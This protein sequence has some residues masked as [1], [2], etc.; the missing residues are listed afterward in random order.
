[1]QKYFPLVILVLIAL[2]TAIMFFLGTKGRAK[3]ANYLF[4][5]SN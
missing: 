2:P 4:P 3:L 1:M 5:P